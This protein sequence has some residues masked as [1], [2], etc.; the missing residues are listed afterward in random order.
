M[1]TTLPVVDIKGTSFYVDVLHEELRQKDNSQNR[2]SFNAFEQEGDGYTFLYDTVSKNVSPQTISDTETESRFCWVTLP[3]LMELDP[4]GIAL[5]YDIPL[6]VLCP[7]LPTTP[8]IIVAT[9]RPLLPGQRSNKK[10]NHQN[11]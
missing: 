5:K 9:I 2:I 8:P 6:E 1:T 7:E 4:E 10:A 3:A 11:S